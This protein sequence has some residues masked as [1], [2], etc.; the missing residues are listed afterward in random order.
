MMSFNK[1]YIIE[2]TGLILNKISSHYDN[3]YNTELIGA[4]QLHY[5]VSAIFHCL[6]VVQALR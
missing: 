2:P 1:E 3:R 5:F 4:L 6:H